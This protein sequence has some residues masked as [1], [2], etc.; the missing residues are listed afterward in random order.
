MHIHELSADATSVWV[1]LVF[2]DSSVAPLCVASCYVPPAGSRKLQRSS[3][4]ARFRSLQ[5]RFLDLAPAGY[6]FCAGDFNAR[7][8]GSPHGRHLQEACN[9]AGVSVCT[10]NVPGDE[11]C[12]PTYKARRNSRASRIDHVVAN[13][14][15]MT[16]LSSC[17]VDQSRHDSD[18]HP[19]VCTLQ[20]PFPTAHAPPTGTPRTLVRWDPSARAR[21]AASLQGALLL[22]LPAAGTSPCDVSACFEHLHSVVEQAAGASGMPR[23]P[24]T[25]GK[26]KPFYDTACQASKRALRYAVS[27]GCTPDERRHLERQYH[28]LVRR[29]K[30]QH[31]NRKLSELLTL[32]RC[33][34]RQ[35]W[36][37]LRSQ[38]ST[39]PP[40]L[41]EPAAWD[42]FMQNVS[43]MPLPL[44]CSLPLEAYPQIS[45]TSAVHLNADITL[46]EVSDMLRILHNGR[47]SGSLGL[48]AELAN[49]NITYLWVPAMNH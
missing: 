23:K 9:E 3:L 49:G 25:A 14:A 11:D 42:A 44:D 38:H 2:A 48:P 39:L 17:M 41:S 20:L 12:S 1:K 18:H 10:G 37:R 46:D 8:D 29:R 47:S 40:A 22:P 5:D 15:C 4:S 27:H 7:L 36:K 35:F 21:Y 26:H 13:P 6:L 30:R 34:P 16:V 33:D 19:I 43:H 28:T 32:Q 31:A 45:T 24:V